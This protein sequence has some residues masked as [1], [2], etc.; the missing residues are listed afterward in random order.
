M[1]FSLLLSCIPS[2][3]LNRALEQNAALQA[4]LAETNAE[5]AMTQGQLEACNARSTQSGRPQSSAEA[6]EAY[7]AAMALYESGAMVAARDAFQAIQDTWPNSTQARQAQRLTGELAV[8]GKPELPLSQVELEWLQGQPNAD[9]RVTFLLFFEQWCPHCRRE[10]PKLQQTYARYHD[11]GLEIVALTRLSKSST[12]EN[13]QAFMA[14]SGLTYPI[15]VE[16][17]ALAN[18]YVVSGIPA[19]AVVQ[20]GQVIW[21]GHPARVDDALIQGWLAQ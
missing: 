9:A 19:L 2:A 1:L 21:R 17:G 11:Q 4:E 20:D 5:L 16:S 7:D 13:T 10:A 12:R 15:A 3:R 14:E 6:Q 8:I 18:H